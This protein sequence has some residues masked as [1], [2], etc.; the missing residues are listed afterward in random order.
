MIEELSEMELKFVELI[1]EGLSH[2][3]IASRLFRSTWTT[4]NY[5]E[6]VR[7]KT[8]SRT[9]VQAVAKLYDLGILK[10]KKSNHDQHRNIAVDQ[11]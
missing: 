11:G 9:M 10:P 8:E 6:E 5:R 1:C 4:Y 7:R 2:E 3:Q